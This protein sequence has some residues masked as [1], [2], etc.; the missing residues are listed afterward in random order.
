M[1]VM[2]SY[3]SRSTLA[4]TTSTTPL[5]K[6]RHADGRPRSKNI[7]AGP[8]TSDCDVLMPHEVFW[9]DHQAWLQQCGY[10]LRP[11]YKPDWV[12][13]W[14]STNANARE[15]EDGLTLPV[16]SH[17]FYL[18]PFL[19]HEIC[20]RKIKIWTQ[21][22]CRMAKWSVVLRRVSCCTSSHELKIAKT[23]SDEPLRSHPK[24]HCVPL[25][26]AL[27]VPDDYELS[28]L[29][30]PLLRPYD[31]PGFGTVGEAL[32]CIRQLLEVCSAF[33]KQG[34]FLTIVQGMQ[35]LHQCRIAHR[36]VVHS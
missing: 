17:S 2:S 31:N 3:R 5:R 7:V 10:M 19:S 15:C 34:Q 14:R 24:N 33:C 12:P 30:Y 23:L 6:L 22:E 28:I 27:D 36:R 35:F 18:P 20:Y 9:R 26:E 29:V 4:S 25:F 11:R 32:E 13:S 1:S 21:F 8:S 16:S